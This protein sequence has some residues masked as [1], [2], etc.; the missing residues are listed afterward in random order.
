MSEVRGQRTIVT[1]VLLLSCV[2]WAQGDLPHGWKVPAKAELRQAGD[3]DLVATADF[4]GDDKPDTAM[5]L[6]DNAGRAAA[7]FVFTTSTSH[8]LKVESGPLSE[9]QGLHIKTV[10][11]GT[12]QTACGKGYGDYACAHGEPKKLVLKHSGV[13]LFLP[14]SADVFFYWDT[15]TKSFKKV[16][17]TD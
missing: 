3:R 7:L 4:D 13:D 8:W 17:I 12:Y 5:I 2:A 9:W 1:A 16:Q 15:K 6:V 14:E 10:K 11:P